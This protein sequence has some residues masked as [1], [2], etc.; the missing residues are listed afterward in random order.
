VRYIELQDAL[1]PLVT[2]ALEGGLDDAQL[3]SRLNDGVADFLLE[4]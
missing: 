4:N 1:S 2:L 3:V